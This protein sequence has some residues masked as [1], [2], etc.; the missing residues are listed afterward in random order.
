MPTVTVQNGQTKTNYTVNSGYTLNVLLGG[1]TVKA[2][3]KGGGTENVY[4]LA[5][6]TTVSNGGFEDIYQG[7]VGSN[8]FVLSG[9]TETVFGSATGDTVSSGGT[10]SVALTV[11]PAARS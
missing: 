8:S 3:I 11:G 10:Q 6:Q 7:G 2:G 4:G 1:T 9:G 5:K